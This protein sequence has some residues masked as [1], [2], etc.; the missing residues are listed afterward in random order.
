MKCR[1]MKSLAHKLR[2]GP[3]DVYPALPTTGLK[4]RGDPAVAL[5]FGS[6]SPAITSSAESSYQPGNQRVSGARKGLEQI[7][8]RVFIGQIAYLCL[9][10]VDSTLHLSQEPNEAFR[11]Q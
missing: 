10:C 5:K 11:C 2:A 9:K 3:T 8:V 1:I 6:I 4:N 7:K